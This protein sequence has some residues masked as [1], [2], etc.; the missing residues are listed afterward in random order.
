M[1]D[2]ISHVIKSLSIKVSEGNAIWHDEGASA[3]GVED[4]FPAFLEGFLNDSYLGKNFNSLL[5]NQDNALATY[6]DPKMDVRRY[7]ASGTVA[8]LASRSEDFG[9]AREDDFFSKPT[10]EG[11]EVFELIASDANQCS[12]DFQGN[13]KIYYQSLSAVPDF[14]VNME[15]FATQPVKIAYINAQLMAVYFPKVDGN[16]RGFYF[17]N[18]PKG[19]KL[20]FVDDAQCGG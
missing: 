14:V 20:V 15:T 10:I 8:K 9:F 11:E 4:M 1:A 19:W 12:L 7:Y 13:N 17:I 6:I 2:I 18:T 3:G 5:C 16:P